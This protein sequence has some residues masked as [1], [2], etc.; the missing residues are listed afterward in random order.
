MSN[1]HK[2]NW[3]VSTTDIHLSI[4]F[5]KIDAET[6]Q[7]SGFATLDNIDNQGDVVLAEAS[8]KAFARARGNLRE[9]HQPIAAGH[10]VDFREQEFYDQDTQKFYRG[11]FVTAYVSTGAEPTW[12]KVLDGT[13]SGFSIGGEIKEAHSEFVKDAGITVRF[14]EDYDL[15]ELS[16]VDNPANHLANVAGFA[17]SLFSFEK[18]A[19]GSVTTVRGMIADTVVENI[20][21]CETDGKVVTGQTESLDCPFCD[22]KMTNIGWVENGSDKSE[23]VREVVARYM[24]KAADNSEGGETVTNENTTNNP[25]NQNT[26]AEGE[27]VAGIDEGREVEA[28]S[29]QNETVD[30]NPA[31]AAAAEEAAG[32]DSSVDGEVVAGVDEVQT[33]ADQIQKQLDSLVET[34]EV[35]LTKSREEAANLLSTLETK[36]DDFTKS[37]EAKFSEFESKLSEFDKGLAAAKGAVSEFEKTLDT[38]NSSAAIKK[39]GEVEK[40]EPV[41]IQKDDDWNGA[42]SVKSLFR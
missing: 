35:S 10:L 11:I 2:S 25:E 1:L 15:I 37:A 7:V 12:Q 9:M 16:L 19:D 31:A 3:L 4:P 27:V 38:V 8:A 21:R 28:G 23:K 41:K 30:G 26:P 20:F 36:F 5:A 24:N 18:S 22:N 17:K 33:E 13:L 14:I 32:V 39:S 40:T 29:Q 6:R 34:I 42:F